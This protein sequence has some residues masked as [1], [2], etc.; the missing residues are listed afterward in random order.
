MKNHYEIIKPL[1]DRVKEIKESFYPQQI[2]TAGDEKGVYGTY[3]KFF[4]I[5]SKENLRK[6]IRVNEIDYFNNAI[7]DLEKIEDAVLELEKKIQSEENNSIQFHA[8]LSNIHNL[9][10]HAKEQ[11]RIFEAKKE[12]IKTKPKPRNIGKKLTYEWIGNKKN[13][14]Q[15]KKMLID[16]ELI[17]NN[18]SLDTFE[19]IFSK[20]P[21]NQLKTPLVWLNDNATQLL[22]LIKALKN[23]EII[24]TTKKNF[25][26]VQLIECFH[27]P[28]NKKFI[29]ESL[30]SALIDIEMKIGEDSKG[31]IDKIITS[32]LK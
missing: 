3:E 20:Q 30:K 18:I 19:F 2:L 21:I 11:I 27:R 16:N 17:E 23:N 12:Q 31:I 8:I 4:Q 6:G 10:Q 24:H 5:Y 22:Y 29:P 26:Y 15:L 25:D 9:K 14:R 1:N 28:N 32:L 7:N 13:I